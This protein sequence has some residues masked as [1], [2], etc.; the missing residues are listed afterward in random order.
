MIATLFT[1]FNNRAESIKQLFAEYMLMIVSVRALV[2]ALVTCM[3]AKYLHPLENEKNPKFEFA[4]TFASS[5]HI[6][7]T[8]NTQV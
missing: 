4:R 5:R 2:R 3:Q 1:I 8:A 6:D 7:E